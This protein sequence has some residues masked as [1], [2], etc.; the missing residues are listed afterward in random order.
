MAISLVTSLDGGVTGSSPATKTVA[1]N[2]TETS[3]NHCLIGIT[4]IQGLNSTI[5]R[6]ATV[7][8]NGV[9]LLQAIISDSNGAGL[10]AVYYLM[11]PSYGNN[12]FVITQTAT[13]AEYVGLEVGLYKDVNT[14]PINKTGKSTGNGTSLALSLTPDVAGCWLIGSATSQRSLSAGANT[15][16]R[17][18]SESTNVAFC[19]SNGS[20][21][22]GSATAINLVNALSNVWSFSG[23]AL[24][25]KPSD[26]T[27]A[28]FL[29]RFV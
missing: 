3:V 13:R 18:P 15:I 20:V 27:G 29:L 9:N 14:T 1:F 17:Q 16:I 26:N 21:P 22:S 28:S 19:D 24:A 10:C 8:Y 12:N 7:A 11:N 5:D 25:P 4:Q 6:L 23:I 2:T